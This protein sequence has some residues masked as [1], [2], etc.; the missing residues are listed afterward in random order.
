MILKRKKAKT[1]EYKK[2]SATSF[3]LQINDN[4]KPGPSKLNNELSEKSDLSDSENASEIPDEDK[5]CQCQQ[6]Y[7]DKHFHGAK[8]FTHWAQCDNATCSHWVHLKY[9]SPVRLVRKNTVF[10]CDCCL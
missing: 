4:Q 6:Y 7:V 3:N 8:E 5:C 9:Y 10:Y 2:N 1:A